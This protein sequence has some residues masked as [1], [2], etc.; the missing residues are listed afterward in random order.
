[1]YKI[2]L[3]S[4]IFLAFAIT[5]ADFES[6]NCQD[7]LDEITTAHEMFT[8][9]F[10]DSQSNQETKD[11][12]LVAFLYQQAKWDL[13]VKDCQSFFKRNPGPDPKRWRL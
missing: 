5:C 8:V 1:M 2:F 6:Q 10:T 7:K 13:V 3:V 4:T 12:C 11:L 9:C